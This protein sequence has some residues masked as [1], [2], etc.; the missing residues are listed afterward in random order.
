[1]SRVGKKPIPIPHKTRVTFKDGFLLVEGEKGRLERTIHPSVDLTIEN[2]AIYVTP[3]GNSRPIL[4]LQGMTRS[5]VANM[6]TG[7]SAGFVRIL[8]INGIGYRAEVSG[9][10]IVFNLGYS[11][12]VQYDIPTGISVTVEKNNV[13]KLS[14]IDKEALGHMAASIRSIRPPEPYKG[15]GVKYAEER[16]QRKAG[17]SGTK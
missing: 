16:I 11:H 15:K 8:E 13:V 9:K 5:L 14:G 10:Q 12:P 1:M 17:K 2:N 6:V 4:A 3:K 7:V